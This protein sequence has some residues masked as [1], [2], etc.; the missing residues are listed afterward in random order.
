MTQAH[1]FALGALACLLASASWGHEEVPPHLAKDPRLG[2]SLNV[3]LVGSLQVEAPWDP[4]EGGFFSTTDLF[5]AGNYGYMGS[6]SSLLHI[7]DISDP[8]AMHQVARLQ[9]PGPALD[10]KVDGDLAIVAVQNGSINEL[11]LVVIDVSDPPQARIVSTIQDPF[12]SGVHNVWLQGDRAYLA[13]SASRGLTVVDLSVPSQPRIS[14]TWINQLSGT[15]SIIHDVVVDGSLAFLSDQ[16]RGTGGLVILDLADPD[17]PRTLS[18]LS[19]DEGLHNCA[20]HGDVLYCNQEL[21]GWQ[22]PL[23][24]IDI[25]DP[26]RPVEIAT[27]SMKRTAVGGGIGPHNTLIRDGLMYWAF[28]DAGFRILDLRRPDQPVEIGYYRTPYAWSAQPHDDGLI[29]VADARLSSFR[30]FRFDRPAFEVVAAELGRTSLPAGRANQFSV[31]AVVQARAGTTRQLRAVTARL[32]PDRGIDWPLR[33]DGDDRFSGMIELPPGL[34]SGVYHVE[35]RAEDDAGAV[36]PFS[37]LPLQLYPVQDFAILD[38][39]IAMDRT[40]FSVSGGALQPNFTATGP[41]FQ[42]SRALAVGAPSGGDWHADMHFDDRLDFLGYTALRFA[43]HPG[44]ARG[45]TLTL[46]LGEYNVRL[47]GRRANQ[48]IDL[49]RAEWQT[50]EIPLDVFFRERGVDVIAFSG[51]LT[52]TFYVDDMRLVSDQ[53]IETAVGDAAAVPVTL[54]LQQNYPNPFNAQTTIPLQL[55]TATHVDLQVF[56]LVGQRV[57]VLAKGPLPA[58]RH[59]LHW[60]GMDGNGRPLATGVYLYQLQVGDVKL[61]RRLLL[62]R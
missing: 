6:N 59:T 5:V 31:E 55:P 22:Q 46:E 18:S 42:G 13:H 62:L 3:T 30:A 49:F 48:R 52:G 17:N 26:A 33:S 44:D 47:V 39:D 34:R 45:Q 38:D 29:Y 58:G 51:N 23:H 20:R 53:Q 7:I 36:Y 25:A 21:G 43:L 61:T 11:G 1:G 19:I 10:V 28:Y 24:I 4:A 57:A 35:I 50:V 56:N 32:V 16:P 15:A 41:V 2:E 12:W 8:A 37:E 60:D 54:A 40:T 14:G 9:M 27:R